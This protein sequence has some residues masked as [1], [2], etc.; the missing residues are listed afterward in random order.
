MATAISFVHQQQVNNGLLASG[1][2]TV[3]A[4]LRPCLGGSSQLSLAADHALGL[5]M[6]QA[7]E[8]YKA[9]CCLSAANSLYAFWAPEPGQSDLPRLMGYSISG[10]LEA[11]DFEA[12]P[13]V[14]VVTHVGELDPRACTNLGV[15]RGTVQL[16]LTED[17]EFQLVVIA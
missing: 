10:N 1:E 11:L 14:G 6:G 9:Q 3:L 13:E 12:M 17:L 4:T 15:E 2:A 7:P 16:R 5:I 8:G